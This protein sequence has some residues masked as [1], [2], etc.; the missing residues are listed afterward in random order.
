[1]HV[2]VRQQMKYKLIFCCYWFNSIFFGY[3]IF[4]LSMDVQSAITLMCRSFTLLMNC[5]QIKGVL[6]PK[7]V[8]EQLFYEITSENKDNFLIRS[9][10]FFLAAL[11]LL[12]ARALSLVVVSGGY[13]LLRCV[14]FS[15][16]WL[17]LLRSTARHGSR[18]AGFSSFGTQ[19]Q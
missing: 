2:G 13:S 10:F 12:A 1:M 9:F 3:F 15:L 8:R 11:G 5:W 6:I 16:R 18:H 7:K 14:G 4:S 17:L 19:A